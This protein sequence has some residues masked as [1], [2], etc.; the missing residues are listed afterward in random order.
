MVNLRRQD[1]KIIIKDGKVGISDECCCDQEGVCCGGVANCI[2]TYKVTFKS[3]M[4]ETRTIIAGTAGIDNELLEVG[5]C[6][7][8]LVWF[9]E[10]ECANI[11]DFPDGM[12]GF[13]PPQYGRFEFAEAIVK[14]DSCCE[15]QSQ[16]SEAGGVNCSIVSALS[17]T[18]FTNPEGCD[19]N[20][21][22]DDQYIVKLEIVS[23]ACDPNI[24][25]CGS[26]TFP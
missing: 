10:C 26:N 2:I 25:P 23:I 19:R 14:C 15:S 5:Q 6:G 8:Y 1:G 18:E 7:F 17:R 20:T 11:E 24:I 22:C 12:G 3:G 21:D 9:T 4:I 13:N 16:Y